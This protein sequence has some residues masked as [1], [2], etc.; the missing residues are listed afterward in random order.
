VTVRGY[1]F[2]SSIARMGGMFMLPVTNETRSKAGLEAGQTADFE[3]ALDTEPRDVTVPEDLAAALAASAAARQA[4]ERLS[5]SNKR[6]LL[7]PLEAIKSAEVR[8]RR[9]ARLVAELGG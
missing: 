2:R 9:V 8:A 3:I 6:R 4:F 1:T 5:Y 7:I